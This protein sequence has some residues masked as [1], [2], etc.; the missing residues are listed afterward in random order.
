MIG[1]S[2][3][4]VK[5]MVAIQPVDFRRGMNGRVALVASALAADPY[6]CVNRDYVAEPS[7]RQPRP[8]KIWNSPPHNISY[9]SEGC[10]IPRAA[11]PEGQYARVLFLVSGV[12]SRLRNGALD[13]GMDRLAEHFFTL[14]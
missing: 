11:I 5:I 8:A 4:G 7:R 12:L 13:G 6:F 9:L 1:L 2:P 14:G 10:G 3:N